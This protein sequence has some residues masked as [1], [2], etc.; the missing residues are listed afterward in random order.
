MRR[1]TNTSLFQCTETNTTPVSD[2]ERE[3]N[4]IHRKIP[5]FEPKPSEY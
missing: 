5:G 2:A 4:E 1:K 3:R